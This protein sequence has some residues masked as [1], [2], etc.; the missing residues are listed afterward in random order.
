MNR[1][2]GSTFSHFVGLGGILLVL[3]AGYEASLHV[4]ATKLRLDEATSSIP[5]LHVL[6]ELLVGL[7]NCL[8]A[9]L[10]VPGSL[11]PIKMED[12]ANRVVALPEVLDDFM[13][14]NH[15]GRV[16]PIKLEAKFS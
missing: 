7:L 11:L 10:T 2:K 16:N 15:R 9:A 6:A 14:F 12:H 5:P 4:H 13:I 1:G 3:Y 8:W